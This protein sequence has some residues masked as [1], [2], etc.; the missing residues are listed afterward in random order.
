MIDYFALLVSWLTENILF[1]S[2]I[3]FLQFDNIFPLCDIRS[4]SVI[5][6]I[7][8]LYFLKLFSSIII[9]L[10]QEN[11]VMENRVLEAIYPT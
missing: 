4:T 8:Y 1:I 10:K 7:I 3:Y 11:Y 6:I 5:S 2:L 9:E